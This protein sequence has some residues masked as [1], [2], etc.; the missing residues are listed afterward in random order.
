[1]TPFQYDPAIKETFTTLVG[2]VVLAE[3]VTN[4][5]TS[6]ELKALYQAE[7]QAVLARVGTG[8]L[9]E[10][11]SLGAWRTAFRKFNVEPTQY[12]ASAEALMRRLVKKG[13]IPFINTLVDLGNLISIRYALPVAVID[14]RALQGVLTVHFAD[15][16]ELYTPLNESESKFPEP[17]E[18]VFTDESRRVMAR[19]WCWRQSE[20]SAAREDTTE[21]LVTIEGHHP[22]AAADVQSAV[23]D[24][25]G[26][27]QKYTGATC[28]SFV[29]QSSQ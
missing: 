2:G 25:I 22:N 6:D 15:G 17:G 3:N 23:T 12:R 9:S 14:R 28:S 5:P 19:R 27:L 4:G 21:I 20:E 24:L 8:S 1:M 13:D 26:L 16:T 18:V 7:Q 10:I 29:I 11:P